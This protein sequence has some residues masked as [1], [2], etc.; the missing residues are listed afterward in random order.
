LLSPTVAR[1]TAPWPQPA[2]ANET[3]TDPAERAQ[4][5]R[6]SVARARRQPTTLW[7]A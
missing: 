4:P 1:G 2:I 7:S 6:R 5:T 3:S